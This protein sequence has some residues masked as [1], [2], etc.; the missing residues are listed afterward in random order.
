MFSRRDFIKSSTILG[1]GSGI[2]STAEA[3]SEK[4]IK[5][6]NSNQFMVQILEKDLIQFKIDGIHLPHSKEYY[7]V[8]KN[9]YFLDKQCYKVFV[10][11]APNIKHL[12]IDLYING[13]YPYLINAIDFEKTIYAHVYKINEGIELIIKGKPSSIKCINNIVC[14]N[15]EVGGT[16]TISKNYDKQ[17]YM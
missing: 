9:K 14:V 11:I 3:I 1:I 15:P 12:E 16:I 2:V 8:F 17:D 13:N 7:T 10:P 4:E 5:D 6:K